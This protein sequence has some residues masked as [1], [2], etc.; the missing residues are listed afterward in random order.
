M[1][2]IPCPECN[3]NAHP[4]KEEAIKCKYLLCWF[5][6]DNFLNPNYIENGKNN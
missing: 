2:E 3:T 1:I 4:T 5:C 6:S